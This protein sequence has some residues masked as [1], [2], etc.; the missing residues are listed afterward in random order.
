MAPNRLKF[1]AIEAEHLFFGTRVLVHLEKVGSY[2][3]KSKLRRDARKYLETSWT[4][5][6]WP[7]PP[8]LLPAM[9]LTNSALLNLMAGMMMPRCSCSTGCLT[10]ILRKAGWG[11]LMWRLSNESTSHLCKSR[12]SWSGIQRGGALTSETSCFLALHRFVFAFGTFC[13]K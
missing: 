1:A 6:C 4:V 11:T 5:F 2:Y 13:T 10:D 7:L 8:S 12:G 9:S 3:L